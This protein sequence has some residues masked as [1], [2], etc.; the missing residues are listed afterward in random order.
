MNKKEAEQRIQKLRREIDHH[1]YLYHVL[2]RQDISEAALD[3][4]KHELFLLEQQH[5]DLITADSPTQRVAGE[6]RAQFQKVRHQSRMFSMEDV[7]TPEEFS[8]WHARIR[9]LLGRDAFRMFCMVK[10]DGLALSLIYKNGVLETAATRGDGTVGE[11]VTQNVKTIE[12]IPLRLRVPTAEEVRKEVS[13]AADTG[14]LTKALL[15]HTGTLEVRGEVYIARDDFAVLNRQQKKLGEENFANPR[16]AAAGALRQLDP[17]ISASR[18]LRFFAWDLATDI[19]QGT[20][21]TEW[22]ILSLLGFRVNQESGPADTSEAVNAFWHRVAEKREKLNFWIDGTVIRV[23]DNAAFETLGV[24]GKAPRGMIAWKFPAEEATTVVEQVD[25]FVGR[26]GVLTPVAVVAATW[27]G[28]TTVHHASLHNM[29]E[30]RR[31]DVRIGDT[32][33]LYKAGDIIPKIKQVLLNLRP[34]RAKEIRPPATC[35]VC[36]SAVIQRP[37]EVA[38]VCSNSRC[39]AVEMERLI[40]AAV[41]FDILGLGPKNIE[42]FVNQGLL[43][44]PADMFRLQ[45]GDIAALERFGDLSAKKIVTEIAQHRRIALDRFIVALGIRHVG[46]ETARDLAKVFGTLERFRTVRAEELESIPNIGAVVAQSISA[47]LNDKASQ[48][49]FDDYLDAGVEVVPV[50]KSNAPTPLAGKTFVLTGTLAHMTRDEAKAA[51]R[52]R[53]GEVAESVSKKTSYVVVGE[54]PGSKAIKAKELRV[55]VLDEEGFLSL[56]V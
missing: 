48:S 41:A 21:T 42:R 4:L 51:I 29:D 17:A 13:G 16:N 35:P 49:L 56:L 6:V 24:V 30:I 31:L 25:W 9:K 43:R 32:V 27:V 14:R 52:A 34:A 37:G 19:G 22:Q 44:S 23:D 36:G 12:A 55:T 2:D 8:S 3:S 5:P 26:T 50:Q 18:K 20:H 46:E 47:F 28:G 45:E 7:F 33:I 15:S 54:D 40:H 10:M 38:F 53:G 11:D 39:Y 1:R